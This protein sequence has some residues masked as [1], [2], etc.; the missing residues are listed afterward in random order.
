MGR[1]KKLKKEEIAED[2]CF[3]CKDGGSLRICDYRNEG[4]VLSF[5]CVPLV[6]CVMNEV[7]DAAIACRDC[8]KSYHPDC[9]G[10]DDSLLES[11]DQWACGWHFC[12]ECKKAPK[13]YC[14]CCPSAVCGHCLCDSGF[15]V[16]R[17]SKG[18][19]DNCLELV[20]LIEEKKDV[21]S[22]GIVKEKEGLTSEHVISAYNLL[23]KGKN[24]RSP[25]SYE[26]DEGEEDIEDFVDESQLVV[27]DYDDLGDTADD[28]KIGKRNRSKRKQSATKRK[29]SSKKREFI[30]WGSKT[31]L[32][33]LDSIGKDTTCE[34]SLYDITN[35]VTQYC[36]EN[37]LFHPERK[38]IIICDAR[39][40][41]L[42]GRKSVNR[43]SIY[44]RLTAHLSEYIDHSED[45]SNSSLETVDE[46]DSV[47]EKRTEKLSSVKKSDHKE[48]AAEVQKSCFASVVPKNIKLVYLRR[49]LVE[50][51]AKQPETFNAKVI[52]S[53]VRVKS[54]PNDYLQ[55]NS[56][57]LVQVIENFK[58]EIRNSSSTSNGV[59]ELTISK[60]SDD[61]FHEDECEDLRQRVINGLLKRPT[62]VEL[63]HNA[64]SLHEDIT[65]HWITRELVSLQKR[66][67]RA[68]EKGWRREYP[69]MVLFLIPLRSFHPNI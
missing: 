2:W 12:Y 63:D 33:F 40:Q 4:I 24:H 46:C 49:S 3:I 36:K 17:G 28:K 29:A 66:I 16:V 50:D 20:V 23:K 56:H 47:V 14:L 57:Q 42:L 15:A 65:K 64:R 43:N 7:A 35:I 51:L 19:C 58:L 1:R 26:Y 62:V 61:D 48:V 30:G 68:N 60:L 25:D 22:N 45:E 8:L 27:S 69:L 11:K 21:N 41:P 52:G 54:D 10:Q 44:N 37:R 18:F 6:T 39:L 31:L 53:F 9:L 55:K 67:D 34:L 59:K 13:F 32:D 38:K 5:H